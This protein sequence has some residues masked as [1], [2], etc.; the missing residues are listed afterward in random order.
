MKF[1]TNEKDLVLNGLVCFYSS[2][3]SQ[4][5]NNIL[6]A[7][8]NVLNKEILCIDLSYFSFTKRFN[9]EELPTVLF[10]TEGREVNRFTLSNLKDLK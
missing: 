10:F 2:K 9:I 8:L 6:F 7:F 3:T 1:L 5:I 4:F